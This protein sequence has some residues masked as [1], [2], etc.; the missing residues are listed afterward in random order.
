MAEQFV[1]TFVNNIN[2][3]IAES[4]KILKLLFADFDKIAKNNNKKNI[5]LSLR[6]YKEKTRTRR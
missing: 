6:K 2:Q 4:T 1:L 5:I 3:L